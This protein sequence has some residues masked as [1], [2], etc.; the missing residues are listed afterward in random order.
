MNK[1]VVTQ[2]EFV[3]GMRFQIGEST[4]NG[5]FVIVKGTNR[6]M[7]HALQVRVRYSY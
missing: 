6:E 4:Q 7:Y 1:F 3:K 5:I 2:R